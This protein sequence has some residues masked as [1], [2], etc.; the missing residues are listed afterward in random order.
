[1]IA[2]SVFKILANFLFPPQTMEISCFCY[3]NIARKISAFVIAQTILSQMFLIIVQSS[4]GSARRKSVIF[5]VT[6]FCYYR[7][8]A[9]TGHP[10][11]KNIWSPF[12]FYR[13]DSH[14]T[15]GVFCQRK[16]L[17]HLDSSML[18]R[19]LLELDLEL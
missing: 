3:W 6:H 7:L 9:F 10:S 15:R 12:L 1:M 16:S 19:S 13:Q 5:N 14:L 2:S 18:P 4:R 8:D 17:N 11:Y